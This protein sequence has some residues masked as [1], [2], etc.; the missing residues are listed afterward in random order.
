MLSVNWNTSSFVTLA[1]ATMTSLAWREIACI[2]HYSPRLTYL[3]ITGSYIL[4]P[5]FNTSLQTEMSV[6]SESM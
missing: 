5:D 6:F 3:I 4:P 2:V 1:N